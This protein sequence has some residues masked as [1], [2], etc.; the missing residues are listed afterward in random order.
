MSHVIQGYK[1]ESV[2]AIIPT[3]DQD[4]AM[5]SESHLPSDIWMSDLDKGGDNGSAVDCTARSG[6]NLAHD[7]CP[8]DKI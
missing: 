4:I 7:D 1:Q 2:S 8:S 3:T 6:G 5:G